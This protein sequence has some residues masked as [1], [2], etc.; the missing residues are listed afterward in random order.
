MAESHGVGG[1]GQV[2]EGGDFDINIDPN[3]MGAWAPILIQVL[4]IAE[5]EFRSRG[6]RSEVCIQAFLDALEQMRCGD[7]AA[8]SAAPKQNNRGGG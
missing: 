4:A 2:P 7:E 1:G 8:P 5:A 6:V 3:N